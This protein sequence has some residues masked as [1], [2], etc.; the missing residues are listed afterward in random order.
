MRIL[1]INGTMR[2]QSTYN[3]GRILAENIAGENDTVEEIFLPEALPHFCMG[4]ATCI[5]TSEEKCPHYEYTS[6]VT[7]KI[8]AADVLIFTTP[9]FAFHTTGQMKALLDHYSYRWMVHRPS[10]KMFTKQAVIIATAAGGGT[11]S[12]IKDIKDSLFYWGV[13]KVYTYGINVQ[14]MKWDE[15]KDKKRTRIE[16]DMKKLSGKVKGKIGNVRPSLKSKLFF[17]FI[18]LMQKGGGFNKADNEYWKN[19][20]WVD[21]KKPW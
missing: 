18:A 14:A 16:S 19:S 20:G 4:C 8:D 1:M 9:V 5:Y 17:N 10:G 2:K 13:G 6:K 3:I 7:E 21:G 12:T 15:V 11:K